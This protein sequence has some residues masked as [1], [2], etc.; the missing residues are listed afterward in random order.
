MLFSC[1]SIV[2]A[3]MIPICS[4]A[5]SVTISA[6]CSIYGFRRATLRRPTKVF[7]CVFGNVRE[8]KIDKREKKKEKEKKKHIFFLPFFFVFRSRQTGITQSLPQLL[9]MCL[10]YGFLFHSSFTSFSDSIRILFLLCRF[11]LCPCFPEAPLRTLG[12]FSGSAIM[13]ITILPVFILL[14]FFFFC[15]FNSHYPG[16]GFSPDSFLP[17]R[18]FDLLRP[19]GTILLQLYIFQYHGVNT[20]WSCSIHLFIIDTKKKKKKKTKE[21]QLSPLHC[22]PSFCP[23]IDFTVK[24]LG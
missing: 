22:G 9:S 18:F 2:C 15:F 7:L 1:F 20:F 4:I 19:L 12:A 8:A 10:W 16:F 24:T 14:F 23:L 6:F 11:C 13:T 3:S 17:D 5:V 21:E